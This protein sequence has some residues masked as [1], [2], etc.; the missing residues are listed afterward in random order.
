MGIV[1]HLV[2][3]HGTGYLPDPADARDRDFEKLGLG[4]SALPHAHSLWGNAFNILDQGASNSC[5]G[6]SIAQGV[7][8]AA[9]DVGL[10]SPG[11]I[12]WNA[13]AF[14]GAT[15]RDD[16]THI[17]FAIR[18]LQKYGAPPEDVWR[19]KTGP[20]GNVNKKPSL[21]SYQ[22]GHDFGG[23]RGYY[24]VF[25]QGPAMLGAIKA[26]IFA[27]RPVVAGWMIDADFQRNDG[28]SVIGVPRGPIIGG[29]A[30]LISGYGGDTFQVVNSWGTRWRS[31]GLATFTAELTM[32][33]IDVWAVDL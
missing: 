1:G 28:P 4:S 5:V 26:A 23:V 18:G 31:G 7:R 20:L 17:R 27:G 29:H 15:K 8:V 25:E 33:A 22:L 14:H 12:Y 32:R 13:R 21:A 24:R 10:L 19:L 11:A 30:M 6:F 16:G 9:P 3:R 2:G